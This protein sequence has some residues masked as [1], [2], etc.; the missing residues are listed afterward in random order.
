VRRG[1]FANFRVLSLDRLPREVGRDMAMLLEISRWIRLTREP[2]F[3]GI[4]VILFE[5]RF[6]EVRSGNWNN[7]KK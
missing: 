6:K 4:T 3:A 1:L 2:I 7:T 5:E